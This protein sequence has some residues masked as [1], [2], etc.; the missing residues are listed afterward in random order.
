MLQEEGKLNNEFKQKLEMQTSKV[1]KWTYKK[2]Q[3]KFTSLKFK[4]MLNFEQH[5]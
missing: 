2:L 4:F 1:H 3:S 5:H